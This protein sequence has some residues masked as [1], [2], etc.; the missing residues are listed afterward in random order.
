MYKTFFGLKSKPFRLNPHLRFLFNGTAMQRVI[1]TL[2]YGLYQREGLVLLTG[3]PGSGKTLLIQ[4]I[5]RRLPDAGIQVH[6]VSTPRADDLSLLRQIAV[7]LGLEDSSTD[8][9]GLLNTIQNHLAAGAK[10]N[11]R[12]L[13]L[14]DEAHNLDD[15]ALEAI[16]LLSNMQLNG[17]PL[18]QIVLVGQPALRTRLMQPR[19]DSLRQRILVTDHLEDLPAEEVPQYILKRL[20]QAGWH[21]TLPFADEAVRQIHL[22]SHGNPRL[23]NTLC[24]R[25]LTQAYVDNRRHVTA[26]DVTGVVQDIATEWQSEDGL[27]SIDGQESSQQRLQTLEKRLELLEASNSQISQVAKT[28]LV[29]LDGMRQ[30]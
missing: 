11:L 27:P 4:N 1:S 25:L 19:L 22:A 6:V 21:E 20:Q 28:I 23:I 24:E 12:R 3:A 18:L 2:K 15:H 13:L 29:R 26:A 5:S 8:I 17:V 7:N 9:G 10:D 16:R 14:I 30:G